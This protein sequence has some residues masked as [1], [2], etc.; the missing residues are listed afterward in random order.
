[1][2]WAPQVP[3][4]AAEGVPSNAWVPAASRGQAAPTPFPSKI[5]EQI[6]FWTELGLG[7]G[8]NPQVL[9][10]KEEPHIKCLSKSGFWNNYFNQNNLL[11]FKKTFLWDKD[12]KSHF[13]FSKLVARSCSEKVPIKPSWS[14]RYWRSVISV[15]CTR[16]LCWVTGPNMVLVRM[17]GFARKHSYFSKKAPA[18]GAGDSGESLLL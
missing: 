1:M 13:L 5:S 2:S 12:N 3:G 8:T 17:W 15:W 14:Y 18:F 6:H 16:F 10:K 4:C 11:S 9:G 7:D